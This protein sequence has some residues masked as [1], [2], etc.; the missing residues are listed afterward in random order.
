MES[1]PYLRGF[2]QVRMIR[3]K[4]IIVIFHIRFN[5][6]EFTLSSVGGSSS[7]QVGQAFGRFDLLPEQRECDAPMYKQA[8]SKE[9]FRH[10]DYYDSSDSED[11]EE[12]P[13]VEYLMY[14]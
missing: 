13:A 1:R 2:N 7:S 8:H 6:A 11:E 14:R 10:N 9:I 4:S 12:I 3:I 5:I